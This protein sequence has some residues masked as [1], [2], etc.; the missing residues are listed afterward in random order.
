[1]DVC[2]LSHLKKSWLGLQINSFRL[3]VLCYLK[4]SKMECFSYKGRHGC[5]HIKPFKEELAWT[6]DKRL[7]VIS[8]MLLKK[9]YSTKELKNIAVLNLKQYCLRCY[10]ALSNI[11]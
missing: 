1:M 6:A 7:Q 2:I 4:N 10:V 11:F 3:S 9:S 5:A 8:T